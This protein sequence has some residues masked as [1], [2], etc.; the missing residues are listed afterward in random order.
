MRPAFTICYRDDVQVMHA[1]QLT[2]L[3]RRDVPP[4]LTG[5]VV[6]LRG[7]GFRFR[8]HMLPPYFGSHSPTK[9]A[10]LCNENTLSV[11]LDLLNRMRHMA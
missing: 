8:V 9:A 11:A 7:H 5:V 4:T 3:R 2:Q 10:D 6:D 1:E